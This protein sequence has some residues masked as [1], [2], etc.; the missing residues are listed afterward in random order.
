[1]FQKR[2]CEEESYYLF[3]DEKSILATHGRSIAEITGPVSVVELGAGKV[4][5]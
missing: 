2:L 1:M 5:N 3:R 4:I